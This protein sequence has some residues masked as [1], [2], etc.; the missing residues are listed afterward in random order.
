MS[1]FIEAGSRSQSALFLERV[2]DYVDEDSPVRVIK[3]FVDLDISGLG[4]KT[5]AGAT[6]RFG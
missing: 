3:V 6:G 2:H 5:E 1:G 4:F